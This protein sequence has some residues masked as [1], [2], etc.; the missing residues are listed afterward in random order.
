LIPSIKNVAVSKKKI[1]PKYK[2]NNQRYSGYKA[3]ELIGHHAEVIYN[4]IE[5]RK[6]FFRTNKIKRCSS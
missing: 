6:K 4:N 3:S 1:F 5:D 2:I